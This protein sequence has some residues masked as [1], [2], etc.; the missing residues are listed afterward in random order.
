MFYLGYANSYTHAITCEPCI[1]FGHQL[2]NGAR[3]SWVKGWV[4]DS[5]C[6]SRH[7]VEDKERYQRTA[8]EPRQGY[9]FEECAC[10]IIG[11]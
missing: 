7:D 3:N 11:E 5:P 9:Y 10:I 8:Q 1:V 6:R 4:W 2:A